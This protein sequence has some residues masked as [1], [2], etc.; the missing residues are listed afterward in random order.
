MEH[1]FLDRIVKR[2]EMRATLSQL[3]RLLGPRGNS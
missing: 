3:I 2:S 1:G